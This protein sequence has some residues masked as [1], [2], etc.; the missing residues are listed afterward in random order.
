MEE[1]SVCRIVSNLSGR[2]CCVIYFATLTP[3]CIHCVRLLTLILYLYKAT[4]SLII[5]I[6]FK[7]IKALLLDN[8]LPPSLVWSRQFY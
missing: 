5:H 1:Y 4:Q 3:L 8:L 2:D 7:L 6:N